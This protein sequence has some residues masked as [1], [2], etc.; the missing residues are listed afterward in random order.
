MAYAVVQYRVLEIPVL[1][2][3]SARYVLVRRIFDL[4]LLGALVVAVLFLQQ[5]TGAALYGWQGAEQG[6]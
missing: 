6:A 5:F 1:L 3:R 4:A 2:K